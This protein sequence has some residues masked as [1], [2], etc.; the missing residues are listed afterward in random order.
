[1]KSEIENIAARFPGLVTLYPSR[2]KWL[3]VFLGSAPFYR[4]WLLDGHGGTKTRLVGIL[5]FAAFAAVAGAMLLPGAG[6]LSL[7]ADGFVTISLFRRWHALWQDATAFHVVRI[8]PSGQRM[9]VYDDR[10]AQGVVAKLNA[11][12]AGYA[13]GLP[14]TYGLSAD[15]LAALMT[16][17]RSRALAQVR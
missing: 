17:W 8:P 5:V 12:V 6:S 13:A 2:K 3:L 16:S 15:E 10:T 7:N 11:A 4:H 9:V 1:M 14:D